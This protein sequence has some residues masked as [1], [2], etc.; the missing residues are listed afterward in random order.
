MDNR[1]EFLKKASMLT[2]AAGLMQ[3]LPPSIQKALAINP[4]PGTTVFDAEHIVFL[5][6]ENRSFD[7]SFGTLQGVR[8]YNDPR[9]IELPNKNKVW[10]QTDGTGKSYCPFRLD[11]KGSKA[12]WM[13]SLPHGW[14]NQVDARN[15]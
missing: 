4:E 7:H 6:Q 2:G 10:I 5:M 15:E 1:R 8:G 11:M 14:S 3:S 13:S 9:A 12:T